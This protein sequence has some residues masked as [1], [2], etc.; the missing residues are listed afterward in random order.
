MSRAFFEFI[1]HKGQS[2]KSFHFFYDFSNFF[3]TSFKKSSGKTLTTL[4]CPFHLNCPLL[5]LKR[6]IFVYYPFFP[7]IRLLI[8]FRGL[9]T[10][11]FSLF[12]FFIPALCSYSF[13]FTLC[14]LNS[15]SSFSVPG[16]F[17]CAVYFLAFENG[18][19]LSKRP[20]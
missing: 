8:S 13:Y 19:K 10:R 5:Y 4:W 2:T 12:I 20:F 16:T 15:F 11:F 9:A 7:F 1:P 18:T 6:N 17:F 14:A 3:W